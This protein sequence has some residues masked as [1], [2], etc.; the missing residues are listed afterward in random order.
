MQGMWIAV[1]PGSQQTHVLNRRNDDMPCTA[2]QYVCTNSSRH[3]SRRI[4]APGRLFSFLYFA[5]MSHVPFDKEPLTLDEQVDQLKKRGML[6][7]DE[8]KARTCLSNISYYR[9][10]AYWYTFLKIPQSNHLFKPDTRF[11]QVMDTY[12]FDRKL[13][14]LIFDEIERIEISIKTRLIQEFCETH[15]KLWYEDV[16]LYTK[17]FHHERFLK[18]VDDECSRTSEVFISHYRRK[19]GN[20][21]RPPAWMVFQLVSFGQL[22]KLFKNL[23]KGKEVRAVAAHYGINEQVLASWLES[24]AFVRNTCA[25]HARLWNRKLPKAPMLP[26]NPAYQW[27]RVVPGPGYANRLYVVLAAM[28]YLLQRFI[29]STSFTTKLTALMEEYPN[30]PKHYMGFTPDW[31]N[32]PL[33][34]GDN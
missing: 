13:K 17:P 33:W 19:Y 20:D 1:Q 30:I 32:E 27:L 25:H 6:I 10:S 7:G 23:R 24:L 28:R 11:E 8:V 15:G 4:S 29:P 14:L 22:S 12:V 2:F 9:L 18:C 5:S 16:S 31:E 3:A 26:T 21:E 34:K